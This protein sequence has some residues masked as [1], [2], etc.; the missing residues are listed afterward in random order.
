MGVTL[1][2]YTAGDGGYIHHVYFRGGLLKAMWI[3]A[4][5]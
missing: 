4:N 5:V 3:K 2:M 1:T